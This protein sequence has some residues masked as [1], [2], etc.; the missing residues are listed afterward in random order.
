MDPQKQKRQWQIRIQT[1]RQKTQDKRR[2]RQQGK[3]TFACD[4]FMTR[5]SKKKSLT[6]CK[7]QIIVTASVEKQGNVEIVSRAGAREPLRLSM[8]LAVRKSRWISG[9][10]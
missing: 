9:S 5:M 10:R 8:S 1:Q 4:F 7:T 3:S 2:K 6:F